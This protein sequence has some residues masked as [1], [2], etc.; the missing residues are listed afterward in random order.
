MH[1][2]WF[3]LC[4][5]LKMWANTC[6][7]PIQSKQTNKHSRSFELMH[8]EKNYRHIAV[9]VSVLFFRY[10]QQ[11]QSKFIGDMHGTM[12]NALACTQLYIPPSQLLL[13]HNSVPIYII[14]LRKRKRRRHFYRINIEYSAIANRIRFFTAPRSF[15]SRTLFLPFLSLQMHCIALRWILL[16]LENTNTHVYSKHSSNFAANFMR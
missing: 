11:M 9:A 14:L 7:P 8:Y 16:T 4:M 1:Q 3:V 12:R 2:N 15:V 5:Y 13:H 6:E 10:S